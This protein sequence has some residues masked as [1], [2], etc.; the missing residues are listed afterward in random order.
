MLRGWRGEGPGPGK[1][2]KLR[3]E[4]LV[5]QTWRRRKDSRDC[6][7]SED[8]KESPL[9]NLLLRQLQGRPERWVQDF[10]VSHRPW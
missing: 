1:E 10:P 9:K 8:K 7:R 2:L 3:K 5:S 6:G 4:R